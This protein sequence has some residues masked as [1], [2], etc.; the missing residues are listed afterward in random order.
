MNNMYGH[1]FPNNTQIKVNESV[2]GESIERRVER[3]LN[4]NEPITNID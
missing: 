1:I 2:E 3:I 4:N